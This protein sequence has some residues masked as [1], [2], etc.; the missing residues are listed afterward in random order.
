MLSAAHAT[1]SVALV[2]CHTRVR[3]DGRLVGGSGP[4]TEFRQKGT[5][6]ERAAVK[7]GFRVPLHSTASIPVPS[8]V[9]M[10]FVPRSRWATIGANVPSVTVNDPGAKL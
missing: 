2:G 6:A 3:P 7:Y 1:M 10:S 4:L 9:T 8:T 5:Y